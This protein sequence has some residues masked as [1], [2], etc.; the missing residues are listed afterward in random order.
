MTPT[1]TLTLT[2]AAGRKRGGL[3][4]RGSSGWMGGANMLQDGVQTAGRCDSNQIPSL[5]FV[6]VVQVCNHYSK[7]QCEP[8]WAEPDCT[9]K[10]GNS[11]SLSKGDTPTHTM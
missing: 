10:E 7:C 1:L 3:W 11:S 4:L 8:G 6:C 2:L 5:S 9:S